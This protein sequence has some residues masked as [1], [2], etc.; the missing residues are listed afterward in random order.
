[1]DNGGGM[2]ENIQELL[3]NYTEEKD[4]FSRIGIKNIEERIQLN[5]GKEYGLHYDS[6]IGIGTKVVV[7]LPYID[8]LV[9]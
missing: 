7:A 8:K 5:F 6:K 1:M 2:P 4:K 3:N 9:H